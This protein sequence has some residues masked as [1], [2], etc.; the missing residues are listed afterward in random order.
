MFVKLET[1]NRRKIFLFVLI[2]VAF[3][4]GAFVPA[5]AQ[6][7]IQI[8]SEKAQAYLIKRIEPVYP[9][10]AKAAHIQ[11]DV[12]LQIEI[13]PNGQVKHIKAVN[14][15]SLL[16][17]AA[18]SAVQKWEY[19][20]FLANGVAVSVTT[21]VKITFSLGSSISSNEEKVSQEYFPLSDKCN[22]A[23]SQRMDP[24]IEVD[25]CQKAAD[26]ADRF[27]PN[28]RYAERRLAYAYLAMALKRDNRAKDAVAAAE[29][30]V[31]I[32]LQGGA[33]EDGLSGAY[34][35]LGQAKASGGDLTGA[36]KDLE[37]AEEYQRKG[38]ETPAGHEL[39]GMYSQTLKS[40]LTFHSQILTALGRQADAQKK[41]EEAAKL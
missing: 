1:A 33:D 15:P 11:G 40:L 18:E 10:I 38:L 35:V 29:K 19:R 9:P 37:A 14:G 41:L 3:S 39:H 30:A 31:S 26:T 27:P 21:T 28:A 6:S 34:S 23:V 36:D 5:S 4:I 7:P 2:Y 17:P 12:T 8:E 32:A 24:A 16:I 13:G 22:H 20:P 25:A